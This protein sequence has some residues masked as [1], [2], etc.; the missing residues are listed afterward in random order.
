M[1]VERRCIYC[2]HLE[3]I[4]ANFGSN[5]ERE[6]QFHQEDWHKCNRDGLQEEEN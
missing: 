4:R 6:R 2:G 3:G 5:R 1:S